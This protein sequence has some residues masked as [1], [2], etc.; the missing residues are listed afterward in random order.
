M[1][2]LGERMGAKIVRIEIERDIT[3]QVPPTPDGARAFADL[4][5]PQLSWIKPWVEIFAKNLGKRLNLKE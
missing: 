1:E 2:N 4:I 3:P 5:G